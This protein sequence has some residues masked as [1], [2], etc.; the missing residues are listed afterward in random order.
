MYAV[1]HEAE[2]HIEHEEHG[3][4]AAKKKWLADSFNKKIALLISVIALFL[5]F[6]ETLGK[7]CK[8]RGSSLNIK[9][10]TP[11]ILPG[12][13]DPGRPWRDRRPGGDGRGRRDFR[14]S[15]EKTASQAG[16]RLDEDRGT[17]SNETGRKGRHARSSRR[18][19]GVR[20]QARDT[21]M[22][23]ATITTKS[24]RPPS[25][26]AS[27]WHRRPSSPAWSHASMWPAA[28]ASS[29]WA[30]MAP[31]IFFNPDFLHCST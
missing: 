18:A 25:R 12:Q 4:A 3:Q 1:Q 27:C 16:R 19:R 23:A 28:W 26:S 21:A 7:S 30:F 20:A 17:L 10:S 14:R 31:G 9:A 2:H 6:A 8:Q 11:G 13:D 5:A 15:Q 24:P 29:D 22:R